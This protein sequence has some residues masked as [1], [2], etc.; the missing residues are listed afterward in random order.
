MT[1]QQAIEKAIEG[2]YLNNF[3]DD[4]SKVID[5]KDED[6]AD[7][8]IS[9]AFYLR[10]TDRFYFNKYKICSDPLFWQALGKSMG[11]KEEYYIQPKLLDDSKVKIRAEYID[12]WHRFIDH[13]AEGKDIESYFEKL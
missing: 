8:K 4:G 11:W 12:V 10:E 9:I 13:L 3:T 7:G 1:L 6:T 5:I 2:G